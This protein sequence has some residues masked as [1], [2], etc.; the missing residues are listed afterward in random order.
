MPYLPVVVMELLYSITQVRS[1]YSLD[2]LLF[3]SLLAQS[4]N[5]HRPMSP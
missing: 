3:L 2:G 4:G 5:P 1:P